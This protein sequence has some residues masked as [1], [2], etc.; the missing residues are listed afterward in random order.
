MQAAGTCTLRRTGG[1]A[2]DSGV[3]YAITTSLFNSVGGMSDGTANTI[4]NSI[5][6]LEAIDTRHKQPFRY[7]ESEYPF[8]YCMVRFLYREKQELAVMK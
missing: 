6:A 4:K 8:E 1:I 3:R 2:F 5:T 7:Y